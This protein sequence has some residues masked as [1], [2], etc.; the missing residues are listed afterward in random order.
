MT[1]V[2]S[3]AAPAA[4]IDPLRANPRSARLEPE[5]IAGWPSASG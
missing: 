3:A 1:D 2:S 5:R 4:A